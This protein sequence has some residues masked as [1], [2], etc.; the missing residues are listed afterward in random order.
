MSKKLE[1][2]NKSWNDVYYRLVFTKRLRDNINCILQGD[3]GLSS[4]ESAIFV[5]GSIE[6]IALNTRLITEGMITSACRYIYGRSQEADEDLKKLK[7]LDIIWTTRDARGRAKEV[8]GKW[9][10]PHAR[11]EGLSIEDVSPRNRH[12]V[13]GVLHVPKGEIS[14]HDYKKYLDRCNEIESKL[15]VMLS[16]SILC[17]GDKAILMWYW[18]NGRGH[19][20]SL[21]KRPEGLKS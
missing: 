21:T 2:Y 4:H 19:T 7:E 9:L 16:G 3:S 20:F 6:A 18:E 8:E 1:Q 5:A 14:S 13:S 17:E 15:R 11:G 12:R 10:I